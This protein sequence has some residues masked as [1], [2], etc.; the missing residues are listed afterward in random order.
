MTGAG[1]QREWR[2]YSFSEARQKKEDF[3]QESL[4]ARRSEPANGKLPLHQEK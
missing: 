4:F 1:K 2:K 3:C